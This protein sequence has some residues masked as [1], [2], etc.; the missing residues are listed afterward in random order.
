MLRDNCLNTTRNN[1]GGFF[2]KTKYKVVIYTECQEKK[3][4]NVFLYTI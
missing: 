2:A 4:N 1:E 3:T